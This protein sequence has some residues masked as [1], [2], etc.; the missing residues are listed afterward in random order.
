MFYYCE[1]PRIICQKMNHYTDS[2][3]LMTDLFSDCSKLCCWKSNFKTGPHIYDHC[4]VPAVTWMRFGVLPKKKFHNMMSHWFLSPGK[5]CLKY[6][7]E[8]VMLGAYGKKQKIWIKIH[9]LIQKIF[10]MTTVYSWSYKCF[11]GILLTKHWK[12]S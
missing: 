12:N 2:P 9:T 6:K 7:Q 8:G 4:S 11:F 10:N 3:W 5:K 1:L